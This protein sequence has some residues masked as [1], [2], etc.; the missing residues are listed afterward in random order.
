MIFVT[1]FGITSCG[2]GQAPGEGIGNGCATVLRFAQE[3]ARVM[4]CKHVIPIMREH[5]AAFAILTDRQDHGIVR[6]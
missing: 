3:G 2:A 4:T 5:R 1:R 6:A